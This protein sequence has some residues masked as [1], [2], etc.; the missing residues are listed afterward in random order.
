MSNQSNQEDE[1]PFPRRSGLVCRIVDDADIGRGRLETDA[2]GAQKARSGT[3]NRTKSPL[4][5][6][7]SRG[8]G[9]IHIVAGSAM[10]CQR[11]DVGSPQTVHQTT[12]SS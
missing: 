4:A 12:I 5:D 8:L 6:A 7:K 10:P 2:D 11:T 3:E 9:A 1:D